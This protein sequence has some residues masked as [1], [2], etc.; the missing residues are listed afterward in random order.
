MFNLIQ[1]PSGQSLA[2]TDR[3]RFCCCYLPTPHDAEVG[4]GQA[5]AVVQAARAAGQE[6]RDL[7]LH[8]VAI[9]R[10]AVSA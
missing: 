4:A 6:Q 3:E 10:A 8:G 2:L 1:A 9:G 5:A 7:N